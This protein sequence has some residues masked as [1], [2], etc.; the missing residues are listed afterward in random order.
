[1]KYHETMH[2]TQPHKLSRVR[3][4]IVHLHGYENLK[5]PARVIQ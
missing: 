1:M 3:S 4:D 2:T 5:T